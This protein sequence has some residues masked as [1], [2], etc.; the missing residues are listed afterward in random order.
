MR[1]ALARVAAFILSGICGIASPGDAWEDD[2]H[3]GLSKW[4]ALHAGYDEKAAQLLAERNVEVDEGILDARTLVFWYACISRDDT[5]S[6][7][8]RDNHF[9]SG[10]G[11]SPP[12]ARAVTPGDNW[13]FRSARTEIERSTPAPD[14]RQDSLRR[15]GT[16]L[17]SL[18]DSWSHQGEPG[19][20]FACN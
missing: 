5:A 6:E 11:P 12:P 15:F 14:D 4:L 20:P 18:Q 17:H 1:A 7:L 16:A 8:V 10:A 9:P 3:F 19:I 2:V 13:V